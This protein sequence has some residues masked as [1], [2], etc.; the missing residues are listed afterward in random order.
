MIDPNKTIADLIST[1]CANVE[2]GFPKGQ[3]SFPLT[4][5]MITNNA[6]EVVIDNAERF[7]A[8]VVQLDVW[9]NDQ[10]R[11]RC[12]TT[13]QAVSDKMISAGFVRQSAQS[14][15]EDNLHRLS[16]SFRG[17]V[18]NLTYQVYERS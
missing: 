16:M 3:P 11:Q 9:D 2:L 7:S 18:D 4:T 1:V 12:E 8:L 10:T 14:L 15:E 13:A 17:I 5:I 6:S